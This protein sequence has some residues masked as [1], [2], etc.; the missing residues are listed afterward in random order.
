MTVGSNIRDAKDGKA[1]E[2]AKLWK[3]G[4]VRDKDER[5]IAVTDPMRVHGTFTS[6]E[7]TT[8]ETVTVIEPELS[9]SLILSDIILSTER[10]NGGTV[11]IQFTDGTDTALIYKAFANDAP[12]SVALAIS[13]RL[14]GWKDARVELIN[15][16]NTDCSLLV[17]YVK[18]PDAFPYMQRN[19]LR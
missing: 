11:T 17:T 8:S 10:Q 5:S 9:G 4:R 12:T 6:I 19:E 14:Q 15:A 13:G 16:G 1:V 3:N 2:V 7:S 18:V